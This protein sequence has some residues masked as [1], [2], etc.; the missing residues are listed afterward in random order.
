MKIGGVIRK[1][2]KE[3]N[4]TQEEVAGFLG[5]TAPAVNKWENGVSM[6]DITLLAPIARLFGITTDTLLTFEEELSEEKLKEI[7]AEL[8]SRI[9]TE[10]YETLFQ[11]VL[12]KIRE[13]PNSEKLALHA[14]TVMDSLRVSQNKEGAHDEEIQ[15]IYERLLD[16]TDE[17]VLDGVRSILY[18]RAMNKEEYDKAQMYLDMLPKRRMYKDK[19]QAILYRKMGKIQEAYEECEKLLVLDYTDAYF[20]LN[21]LFE[22]AVEEKDTEKAEL[23][24]EKQVV[25]AQLFEWGRYMELV[26]QFGLALYRKDRE[27]SLCVLEKLL[28]SIKEID[29]FRNSRLYSHMKMGE[30][31]PERMEAFLKKMFQNGYEK[32]KNLEFLRGDPRFEA[33]LKRMQ[34]E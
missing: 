10:D 31:N 15:A 4:L 9:M 33:L 22:L 7:L 34:E 29:S 11:W 19:Y 13:Y 3:K 28:D 25:L 24:T 27:E 2:R 8:G 32:D 20:A 1:Y 6:P 17:E 14:I 16:S 18:T 12:G 21:M 26:P 30:Y 23:F 5:V